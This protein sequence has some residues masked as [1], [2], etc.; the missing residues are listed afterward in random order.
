MLQF[1]T[2]LFAIAGLMAAAG[3]LI[4]HL[5]NRRNFRIVEWGAMAFLRQALERNRR[6]LE[7]RDFL[8]LVLRAIAVILLGLAFARP[9]FSGAGGMAILSTGLLAALLMGL[10]CCG[11]LAIT[12]RNE[13]TRSR[14][15]L[16]SGVLLAACLVGL[17]WPYRNVQGTDQAGS[18]TEPV[19]AVV[20]LDNSR[21]MG[22]RIGAKSLFE[23]AADRATNFIERLPAGSRVT[24]LPVCGGSEPATQDAWRSLDEARRAI[25]RIPLTDR[26]A[27]INMACERASAACAQV[28]ELPIK[29]VAILSD[30]QEANWPVDQL[31]K[32]LGSLEDCQIVPIGV[33]EPTGNVALSE[34]RCPD[35]V[36]SSE[37]AAGVIVQLA[38]FS[39]D[40]VTAQIR[41]QVNGA[42]VGSQ[43]IELAGQGTREIEFIDAFRFL[44]ESSAGAQGAGSQSFGATADESDRFA[45]VS[46]KLS[47]VGGR[48]DGASNRLEITDGLTADNELQ[49]LVPVAE[50]VPI[51]FVDEW[52]TEER[53][54]DG[55]IGETYALRH[56]LSPRQKKQDNAARHQSAIEERHVRI[57]DLTE[58]ILRDARLVVMAGVSDPGEGVNLLRDYVLQGGPL[59]IF[60]GGEFDPRNWNQGAWL[61]GAGILP[62]PLA[63]EEVGQLPEESA[64]HL[65]PFGLDFRS[66]QHDY[67]LVE[68][69]DK[70][71][72]QSLYETVIFFKAVRALVDDLDPRG[73]ANANWP[74][75]KLRWWEWSRSTPERPAIDAK[76]GETQQQRMPL[77][78]ARFGLDELPYLVE[79]RMGAGRVL[80]F[81]SGISSNWNLL[82]SSPGIAMLHRICGRLL[83][84]TYDQRNFAAGDA[85]RFPIEKP[86]GTNLTLV[87]PTGE[88]SPVN[89]E[90]IA[91]GAFGI[92]LR[93]PGVA[94][95]YQVMKDSSGGASAD[96][97]TRDSAISGGLPVLAFALQGDA[98]ESN[99]Q[100]V[101]VSKVVSAV[102]GLPVAV[103][104]ADEEI[105]LTGGGKQGARLWQGV[106]ATMLGVLFCEGLVLAQGSFRA[107]GAG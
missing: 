13:A 24:V 102:S 87:S 84:E 11:A 90:A 105:R 72:L 48:S 103:L 19:H 86:R 89:V 18:L 39:A 3:P 6:M 66:M 60:A 36:A 71:Q 64:D 49:L 35:G 27:N 26:S 12:S 33:G 106:L 28:K 2:S 59:M 51:V 75:G 44:K 99:L 16:G 52:G 76:A 91:Q 25:K 83:E 22:R 53:I 70:Q 98:S 8:L 88:R 79:R 62:C 73:L 17:W 40:P 23:L 42:E 81:T 50:R 69:E 30:L 63:S 20:V 45:R 78:L 47:I 21:S 43:T 94:G 96:Q 55:R 7:L 38:S 10:V 15:T 85:I 80:L 4:I 57:E 1:E 56:L 54:A 41:L 68:N 74:A 67:F 65:R 101:P 46:A 14:A 104:S 29:R 82:R 34:I 37:S 93:Q 58:E 31:S 107:G 5:L 9:F 97:A 32:W 61:D 77:V 95:L 92:D 100:Q